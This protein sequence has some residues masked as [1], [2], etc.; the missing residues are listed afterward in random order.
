[1]HHN[2]SFYDFPTAYTLKRSDTS[3][4]VLLVLEIKSYFHVRL[5][6]RLL[7]NKVKSASLSKHYNWLFSKNVS[8]SLNCDLTSRDDQITGGFAEGKHP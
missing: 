3:P 8:K 4:A 6:T 5:A 1:M 7:L 2:G